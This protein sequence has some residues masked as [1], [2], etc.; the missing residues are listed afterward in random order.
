MR[1]KLNIHKK[2]AEQ[3]NIREDQVKT[4]VEL[5]DEGNTIPFIAR[6]RKEMTGN[7]TDTQLRDLEEQLTYLRKLI[8]K[9]EEV[10]RL[11]EGQGKMTEELQSQID[12]AETLSVV[13]DIYLP[14]RPKK[15]T[16]ATMAREKG[17]EPLAEYILT[18]PEGDDP[19]STFAQGYINAELGVETL[20][21]AIEGALDI[22]AEMVSENRTNRDLVRENARK[23]GTIATDKDKEVDTSEK[24]EMYYDYEERLATIPS[25]R[26]LAINRGEKE[27][28]LKVYIRLSD[29]LNVD[30]I[31]YQYIK[32]PKNPAF[33]FLDRAIRDSYKR[34]LLPA[35][36]TEI[37]KELKERADKDS[38]GVF[39]GNLKPY[40]MQAPIRGRVIM[41]LDPGFRTGC[42]VAVISDL[43][44]VLDYATIYPTQPHNKVEASIGVMKNFVE[45]YGVSLIAIGNGTASRETE[46]VVVQLIE[47]VETK[48]Y[49]SIVNES[50]ASIYSASKLGNEEFPDLDV[51]IR[52]AIS[53]ARRIQD[54]M[55]EL[56]KI[57]PQHIG[58]GQYQHDVNQ[59]ALNETLSNVIEDCVNTVGVDINTASPALLSYVSGITKTTAEN[60]LT[61]KKENGAFAS[62]VDIKKVKGIGPKAFTQCAGFLRIPGGKNPLDNT[63]VHPESYPVA[64]KLVDADLASIDL[65]QTAQNLEV[66]LPTLQDIVRELQKPG[67]DPREDMPKPIL[68]SDVLSMEDLE[69]GMEMKGTVRNVVDFGCF[70]DIGVKQD[71]LVH[72]SQLSDRYVKHPKEVVTVSDVVNVRIIGLDMAKER[73]SLSMKG[74]N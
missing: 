44:E 5:I 9:K 66:G 50:G 37:R 60:I 62:R 41:G 20:D 14:F 11:I 64:K 21:D 72:L 71:G 74:L 8:D 53:I 52:G 4:T 73:I 48:L 27:G 15:R 29:D 47:R 49:Y 39:A 18:L 55:A 46:Q 30:F 2:L 69:I 70:V 16:R 68:C 22:I 23:R 56:V 61:W 45:K 43:G 59:K 26:V 36:E 34:L 17:L 54:P 7:L 6:Y 19:I 35:M 13:E 65:R 10:A 31:R 12:E 63:G 57:E 33:D 28:A 1:R 38:I 25:H 42:K 24:Y 32:D 67:R 58:V 40:I 51:T 3:L